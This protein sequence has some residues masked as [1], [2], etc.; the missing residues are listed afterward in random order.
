MEGGARDATSIR[1]SELRGFIGIIP[2]RLGERR[3]EGEGSAGAAT[4]ALRHVPAMLSGR[5][6]RLSLFEMCLNYV[7][8]SLGF[9]ESKGG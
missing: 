2:R 7:N 1:P 6:F 9:L 8:N 4:H 5:V 3:F